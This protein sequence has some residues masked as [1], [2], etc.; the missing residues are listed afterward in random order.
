[1]RVIKKF[2][3]AAFTALHSLLQGKNSKNEI[4]LANFLQ[5]VVTVTL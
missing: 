2:P 1:M 3:T 4:I 5:V